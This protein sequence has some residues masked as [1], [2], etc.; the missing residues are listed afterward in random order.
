MQI[1][2][3]NAIGKAK[4]L[5]KAG[6]QVVPVSGYDAFRALTNLGLIAHAD[7]PSWNAIIGLRKLIV[8]DYMNIDMSQVIALLQADKEQFVVNFL[9]QSFEVRNL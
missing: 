3:E 5:L 4:Q 7:L 1:L 8:H 9:R 2:I 6:D